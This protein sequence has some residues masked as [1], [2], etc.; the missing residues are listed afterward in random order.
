M[1][2]DKLMPTEWIYDN[3]FNLNKEDKEKIRLEILK[4]QKRKF[5]WQQIEDE[6]NDPVSSGEAVGTQGAMQQGGGEMGGMSPDEL[7]S[8][9][10]KFGISRSGNELEIPEDGWPGAGR[11]P[12]PNKYSKD[13]G[14][15]GRDPLGAHDKKKGG[16]GSPRYGKTLALAHYD[17]LM[18]SLGK[19]SKQDKKIIQETS[20][21]ENEYKNEVENTL[22][23]RGKDE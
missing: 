23:K 19:I 3:V 1:M 22:N 20:D 21:V 13:S 16:S 7:A 6:G 11:P 18:K 4:D 12:E 15:R 17:S 10:E 8:E 2:S 9:K 14:V 5:R